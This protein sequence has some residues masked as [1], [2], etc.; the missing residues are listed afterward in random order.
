MMAKITRKYSDELTPHDALWVG[1]FHG[2]CLSSQRHY[3][4]GKIVESLRPEVREALK[5]LRSEDML[6]DR[7]DYVEGWVEHSRHPHQ[8]T[9]F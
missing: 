7:L 3:G 8:L 2:T 5:G 9:P 4:P 6:N 1:I